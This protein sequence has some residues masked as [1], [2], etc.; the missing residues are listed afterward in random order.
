[1][2]RCEE[3][4]TERNT[5]P[6][7]PRKIRPVVDWFIRLVKGALVGIGF[8]LPGLSGGVLAVIFG[9]YNPLIRFLANIR[10]KFLKNVL[11]FLPVGIGAAIG[12]VLF[13]IV[14]EKAF[15]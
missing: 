7:S 10:Y 12:I 5:E 14:V 1:M 4:H 11:Y 3:Q 15:G 8:I 9:I 6:V 13:A 2:E